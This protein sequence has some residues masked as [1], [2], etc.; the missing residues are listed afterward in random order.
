MLFDQKKTGAEFVNLT[1]AYDTVWHR[2]LTCELLRLFPERYMVLLIIEVVRNQSFS[3]TTGARKENKLRRPKHSVPQVSV[4]ALLLF[5]IYTCNL[6]E[7]IGR[8]FAYANDLAIMYDASNWQ[9]LEE[10]LLRI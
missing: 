3:L 10:L 6:F 9:A 1:A 5:N 7:T 4:L 8:K 2:G